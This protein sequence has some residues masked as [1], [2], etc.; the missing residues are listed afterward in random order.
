MKKLFLACAALVVLGMMAHAP[1]GAVEAKVSRGTAAR[2]A[3]CKA[4]CLPNNYKECPTWGCKGMHGLYRSY[5]QFDPKLQSIE[6]KKEFAE[7]VKHCSDPLPEV[8]VEKPIFAMGF[9]WFGKSADTCLDCHANK[10]VVRKKPARRR[11]PA[12]GGVTAAPPQ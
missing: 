12:T 7:C 10:D 8:Y 6:G 5:N 4:D 9:N 2:V 11:A 1:A 3:L